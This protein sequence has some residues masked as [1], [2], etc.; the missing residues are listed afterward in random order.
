MVGVQSWI[1]QTITLNDIVVFLKR[2]SG[3]RGF[4]RSGFS[5]TNEQI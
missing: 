3:L 1:P 2:V 4:L 5:R